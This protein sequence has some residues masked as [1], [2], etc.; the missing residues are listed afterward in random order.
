M[1]P[2]EPTRPM[3]CI[4]MTPEAMENS[5]MGTTMNF[6]RFRKIVPQGRM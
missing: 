3:S 4:E 5:T 1:P 6:S 2:T